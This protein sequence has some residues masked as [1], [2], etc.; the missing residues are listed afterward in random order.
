[1]TDMINSKIVG[2]ER[3]VHTLKRTL[4]SGR[5]AH[6]YIFHGP[7]GVGKKAAAFALARA[8]QCLAPIGGEAC[9]ECGPCSKALK[10][11]HPDI[12]VL[13]PTTK[14]ASHDDI[15][16]RLVAMAADPYLIVDFQRKPS[17]D[18][19]SSA[20][21]KQVFYSVEMV[22]ESLRRPMSYHRV[23]GKYRIAIILDADKL[24][25]DAANAFLKLLE[26]PGGNTV[27]IL[28]TDRIDHILPTILSRCQQMR[29]DTLSSEEITAALIERD[30][31]D[32]QSGPV[33][34]RMADGSLSRALDLAG[35][36]ELPLVRDEVLHF[37]RISFQGRGDVVTSVVDSM[38]GLG[39]EHT[40]FFLL[41]M[42]GT[43]RDLFLL[44][45]TGSSELIVS[46]DQSETL[47][48]F[49]DNLPDAR[50]D[51]MIEAVEQVSYLIERN[52]NTRLALISLSRVIS[53]AMKGERAEIMTSLA[54]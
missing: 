4:E 28:T 11:L 14:D 27:F 26:E 17:L 41:V 5:I 7:D 35:S 31:V 33:I 13:M 20:S 15:S 25:T 46:V 48:K 3:V 6:A 37:L 19:A 21:N 22:N 54:S 2:Q 29:F 49:V 45:E 47:R 16:S 32:Q 44:S 9:N 39:R 52:V 10:G 50:I 53:N 18:G 30:L 24:R 1:M 12:H 42:L 38:S 36:E 8:L 23:E 40:K 51:Y 34:A 43:L